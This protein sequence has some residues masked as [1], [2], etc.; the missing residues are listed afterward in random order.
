[1]I[2]LKN[3]DCP[4]CTKDNYKILFRDK[5]RR[6][7]LDIESNYVK[8]NECKMIYL[9]PIPDF[10][11][12]DKYNQIYSPETKSKYKRSFLLLINKIFDLF[13][14]GYDSL[15]SKGG[16]YHKIYSKKRSNLDESQ[17]RRILDVGCNNGEKLL[18]YSK[19]GWDVFRVDLSSKSIDEAK[20]IIPGG[21][22]FCKEFQKANLKKGSFDIIRAD[23]VWEHIENPL[24]FVIDCK[25]YLK[26]GGKLAL[27]V[28]NGESFCMKIFGR[29]N[30]NSWVPFH[31]NLF[32]EKTARAM[33]KNAGFKE[34]SIFYNTPTIYFLLSINQFLSHLFKKKK[35]S[36]HP[37]IFE[38]ISYIIFSPLGYLL[39]KFKLGEELVI[40]A[41]N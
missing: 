3:R 34:I 27:Y 32:S 21:H 2:E 6:E 18:P 40:I 26:S 15:F 19:N 11:K 8:C 7:G 33:L 36:I 35:F 12:F 14:G 29:Y 41:K 20:K 30:I 31:I 10:K 1:M 4:L 24:K 5:N 38:K 37:S 16:Y 23:A 25:K 17:S 39:N 13:L 22:F 9:D 28:P